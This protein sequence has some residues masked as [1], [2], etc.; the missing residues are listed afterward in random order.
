MNQASPVSS[1]SGLLAAVAA[2]L[3]TAAAAWVIGPDSPDRRHA[4]LFSAA[5]C[6]IGSIGGG[7]ISC[8]AAGTAAGRAA[9]PL[10]SMAFRLAPALVA[11]G[12]LQAGGARLRAAGAGEILVGCYLAA[13]GAEVARIIIR[14]RN[15]GPRPRGGGGV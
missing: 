6:L 8:Q 9:L 1:W 12:W 11:L 7:V 13:L 4:I 14:G 3:I 10:A 15:P 2:I 5:T